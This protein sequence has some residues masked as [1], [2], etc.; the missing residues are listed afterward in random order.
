M[1]RL[2]S[3]YGRPDPF[4]WFDGGR[5]GTSKFAAMILHITGQRISAAA[6]FT[7]FDRITAASGA[8]PDARSL[9]TLGLARLRALGLP[10][11]KARCLL[12]LAGPAGGGAHRPGVHERSHR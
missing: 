12:E 11:A 1:A 3:A 9:L 7:V 4:E 5:T 10:D 8:V 6:A 2:A